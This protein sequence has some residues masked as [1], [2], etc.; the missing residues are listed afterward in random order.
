MS[1]GQGTIT[2]TNSR[3]SRTL[4]I[5]KTDSSNGNNI[6]GVEYSLFISDGEGGYELAKDAWDNPVDPVITDA[7]GEAIFEGLHSGTYYVLETMTPA[8]YYSDTTYHE[9]DINSEFETFNMELSNNPIPPSGGGEEPPPTTVTVAGIE[10][11]DEEEKKVEVLGVM[12]ELPFTGIDFIFILI[13]LGL[14]GISIILLISYTKI[15][16]RKSIK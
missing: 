13:G 2:I 9:I 12:E 8:G 10:E 16:N 15:L 1:G 4:I 11:K 6:S 14:L 7:N 5:H 3:V